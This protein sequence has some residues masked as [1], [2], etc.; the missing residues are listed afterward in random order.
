MS[1]EAFYQR[2]WALGLLERAMGDLRGRYQQAGNLELFD[3]L[4]GFLGGEDDV[5]PY[6]ELSRRLGKSEG[7]LRTAVSRLRDRWRRRVRELVDETADEPAEARDE[8]GRLIT[9]VETPRYSVG[10][11]L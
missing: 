2:R 7:A 11:S 10:T 6:A 4:K 5:L 3:A 9:A 1:P 8:L